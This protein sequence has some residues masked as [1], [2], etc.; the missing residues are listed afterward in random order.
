MSHEVMELKR[1]LDDPKMD[2]SR[3][4]EYLL[5]AMYIEMLG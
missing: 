5:R 4:K 3:L 2:K 1:R